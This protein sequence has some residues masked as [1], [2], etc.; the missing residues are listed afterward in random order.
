MFGFIQIIAC[1]AVPLPMLL[2]LDKTFLFIGGAGIILSVIG[3]LILQDN[4]KKAE[5]EVI[6]STERN[7]SV[8]ND[9]LDGIE[10]IFNFGQKHLFR[11]KFNRTTDLLAKNKHRSAS[12]VAL[13]FQSS[14]FILN[15]VSG[16]IIVVAAFMV[17][18]GRLGIGDYVV[19]IGISPN[20][21][22]N[23]PFAIHYLQNF[24]IVEENLKYIYEIKET[25]KEIP[26]QSEEIGSV[27][28]ISFKKLSFRYPGKDE[29]ILLN[30][31]YNFNKKGITE[32]SGESGSGKSTLFNLLFNYYKADKGGVLINGKKVEKNKNL[33][34]IITIMRQD[35][36]FFP[37]SLKDNITMFEYIFVISHQPLSLPVEERLRLA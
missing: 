7:L 11:K 33:N 27:E 9:I 6:E 14:N 10:T 19:S 29:D 37:G 20:L 30:F 26:P 23:V 15:L 36:I 2:F 22:G 28:E 18:Q 1:V 32:I 12:L 35:S 17:Y 25:Y 34:E 4:V 3:P 21:I 31:S 13:S 16:V 5:K 24:I 8:L